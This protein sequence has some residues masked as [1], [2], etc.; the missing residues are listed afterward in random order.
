MYTIMNKAMI[1][2]RFRPIRK[3]LDLGPMKIFHAAGHP[4]ESAHRPADRVLAKRYRT[5][6]YLIMDAEPILGV[7]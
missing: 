5:R 3:N 2:V 4:G 6:D 1:E 7:H